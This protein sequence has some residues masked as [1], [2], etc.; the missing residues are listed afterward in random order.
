VTTIKIS[1]STANYYDRPFEEALEIIALAGFQFV[2]LDLFWEHKLWAMA[3]HLRGYDPRDVVRLIHQAGLKVASIHDG[4]GVLDQPGSIRG[5]INPQ[6]NAYLD[7]LSYAPDCLVF[8]TPHIEGA[9]DD[10]WWS[11]FAPFVLAALEPYRAVC[12]AVTIENMPS[13]DGY[14]VPLT[15]PEA[16]SAFVR[17]ADLGVTLDTTHYAQIDIDITRAAQTLFGKVKTVHFSDYQGGKTHVFPGDGES[18]FPAF[19]QALDA[20]VLRWITLECA[21]C[22]LGEEKSG[23]PSAVLAQR[24]NEARQRTE[25]WAG[26]MLQSL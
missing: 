22:H 12:P 24:L 8:H 17:A 20:S 6:I 18:D 4:G 5:F 23:L 7:Q 19:F 1:V 13:F 25:Q 11:S 15:T 3:Q 9:L 26:F 14:F 2:E 16:L 21:P 10:A